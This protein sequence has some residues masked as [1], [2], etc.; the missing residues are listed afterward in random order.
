V[1]L[2][3]PGLPLL[4]PLLAAASL[5]SIFSAALIA[6]DKMVTHHMTLCSQHI[7]EYW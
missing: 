4:P 7:S 5:S 3:C 2:T 6:L 1:S